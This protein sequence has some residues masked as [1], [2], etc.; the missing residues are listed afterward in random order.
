MKI[1]PAQNK[2]IKLLGL[3]MACQETVAL[4]DSEQGKTLEQ[5]TPDLLQLLTLDMQTLVQQNLVNDTERKLMV[6]FK[7]CQN[8]LTPTQLVALKQV[9]QRKQMELKQTKDKLDRLFLLAELEH[10]AQLL[11]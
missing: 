11:A 5:D 4:L 1:T 2:Q 10:L 3:I 6:A 8:L 7:Q 9:Q